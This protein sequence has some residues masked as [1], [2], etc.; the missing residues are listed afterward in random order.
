MTPQ[1]VEE[2]DENIASLAIINYQKLLLGNESEI[3]AM[4]SASTQWGFFY[5][6]LE[7]IED[8]DYLEHVQRLFGVSKEYFEKPPTEKLKD[9]WTE[10]EVFNICGYKPMGLDTG[11]VR[12]KKDGCE[13]LRIPIDLVYKPPGSAQLSIPQGIRK[14]WS[15]M[16]KFIEA[17]YAMASVVL[18]RLS[19]TMGL[20]G[21]E[22]L[23]N[24]HRSS[25]SSTSTAVLQ[26]YPLSGLDPNTSPGHFTHTDA[27]SISI[28]FSSDWGLQAFDSAKGGWGYVAPRKH[29]AVVNIGDSL[30]FLSNHRLK[31]CLHRVVPC[32]RWNSGSRYSCIFFLRPNKET[33]FRD[34][35]GTLWR[36]EDWLNR[37]FGNYRLTHEEQKLT[38]MST[39]RRNFIG[40]W[41]DINE[42]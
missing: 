19:S 9:T 31:S 25:S 22:E 10:P 5:L 2:C 20:T 16:S 42:T 41:K 23:R 33:Q 37:K 30:R 24:Y 11:N 26:H 6:S 14:D 4:Y 15:T 1:Q 17:S 40:L 7:D 38:S 18:E 32:N 3:L 36:A 34:S 13:G 27:G 29:C 8:E 28:L 21:S 35:D 12:N 39:G